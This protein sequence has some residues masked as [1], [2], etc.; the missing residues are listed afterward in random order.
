MLLL[1]APSP[2]RY[3]VDCQK[4]ARGW[5]GDAGRRPWFTGILLEEIALQSAR[6]P[7]PHLLY[8]LWTYPVEQHPQKNAHV[9]T[10]T[11]SL[12]ASFLFF[13]FFFWPTSVANETSRG[14]GEIWAGFAQPGLLNQAIVQCARAGASKSLCW[15]LSFLDSVH[16][17]ASRKWLRSFSEPQLHPNTFHPPPTTTTTTLPQRPKRLYFWR[18]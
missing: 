9:N 18:I 16:Y 15:L 12:S 10:N 17:C 13:F 5:V 2:R 1:P 4:R 6:Q 14:V 3:G 11:Y 7:P 8:T